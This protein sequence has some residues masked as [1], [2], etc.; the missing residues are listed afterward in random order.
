MLRLS[1]AFARVLATRLSS[2]DERLFQIFENASEFD[3]Y[4]EI[5]A[6]KQ[7]LLNT[8]TS[9]SLEGM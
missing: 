7:R 9:L 6:W 1:H 4:E 5:N 3:R 2:M 8:W